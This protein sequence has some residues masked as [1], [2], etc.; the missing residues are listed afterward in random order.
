MKQ[1]LR[2]VKIGNANSLDVACIT[3]PGCRSQKQLDA[4][5]N[6]HKEFPS[7]WWGSNPF[8]PRDDGKQYKG[9]FAHTYFGIDGSLHMIWVTYTGRIKRVS[10]KEDEY[11]GFWKKEADAVV[12][13]YGAFGGDAE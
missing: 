9:S 12:N 10:E 6:F 3:D 11:T 13:L 7:A 1:T 4:V 2:N 5:C 8:T